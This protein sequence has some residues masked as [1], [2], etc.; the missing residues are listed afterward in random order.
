[1]LQFCRNRFLRESKK[2]GLSLDGI[3]RSPM[4][5]EWRLQMM[6]NLIFREY[7]EKVVIETEPLTYSTIYLDQDYSKMKTCIPTPVWTRTGNGRVLR[8]TGSSAY[9]TVRNLQG[10]IYEK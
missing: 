3:C 8:H 7:H 6:A 4:I 1:M 10:G 5:P 2:K 9:S